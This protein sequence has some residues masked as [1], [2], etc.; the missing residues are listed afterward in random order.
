MKKATLGNPPSPSMSLSLQLNVSRDGTSTRHNVSGRLLYGSG[1]VS[2]KP[3]KIYVNDVEKTILYTYGLNGDFSLAGLDLPPVNNQPTTYQIRAVFEGDNPCTATAYAKTPNGTSYAACTT[4]EYGYKP[5]SNSASVTVEA[6]TSVVTV[7]TKTPEQLQQEAKQ[8]GWLKIRN[9]FTW[10]YPWYR[11]HFVL[12]VPLQP[13]GKI[14]INYGWSPL[15]FGISFKANAT[16]FALL[17]NDLGTE[18]ATDLIL[19]LATGYMI[20]RMAAGVAGKTIVG[21]AIAIG[22]YVGF[23]LFSAAALYAASGN[24]P[25]AWLAAFLSSAIGSFMDLMLQGLKDVWQWLTAISRRIL[26][27]ISHTLNSMWARGLNFFDITGIAFTFI[28]F[29]LMIGYLTLY[30]QSVR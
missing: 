4:I 22:A 25:K 12:N 24:K 2:G 16:V 14:Y 6:P 7:P 5:S 30:I 28:D 18:I 11:M 13:Y 20:Q 17:L 21:I 3:V 19:G 8:K 1:G 27:E 10:W 29:A 26:D 15:P 9:E 23:S